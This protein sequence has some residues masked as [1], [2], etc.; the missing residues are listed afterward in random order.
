MKHLVSKILIVCLV[1]WPLSTV[2]ARTNEPALS[3]SKK[4]IL[5]S[6]MKGVAEKGLWLG[7]APPAENKVDA[8]NIAVGNAVLHYLCA[9]GGG[10][11]RLYYTGSIN[12]SSKSVNEILIENETEIFSAEAMELVFDQFSVNVIH[13]YYNTRGECFVACEVRPNENSGNTMK[14][15]R[16][17]LEEENRRLAFLMTSHINGVAM[18]YLLEI[19][20]NEDGVSYELTAGDVAFTDSYHWEY[21]NVQLSSLDNTTECKFTTNQSL[22]MSQ[23]AYLAMAPFVTDTIDVTYLANITFS[24]DGTEETNQSYRSIFV[25]VQ[26][27]S[28]GLGMNFRSIE[29][30]AFTVTIKGDSENIS[31]EELQSFVGYSDSYLNRPWAISPLNA[32]YNALLKLA[33]K[34]P[35]KPKNALNEFEALYSPEKKGGRVPIHRIDWFLGQLQ[36]SVRVV[37]DSKVLP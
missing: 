35:A 30:N 32:Y 11:L 37:V 34:M 14:I 27:K 26:G 4:D 12:M 10:L 17:W 25:Q 3:T 18:S 2:A 19:P 21:P 23:M 31:N 15:Q 9:N 36:S 1:I 28:K 7:V 6:W 13:E 16:D 33:E 29:R 8:R 24:V 5:P 20:Y 22:G